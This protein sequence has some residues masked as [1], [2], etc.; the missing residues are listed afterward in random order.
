MVG[1]KHEYLNK[2]DGLYVCMDCSHQLTNDNDSDRIKYEEQEELKTLPDI[3]PPNMTVGKMSQQRGV[4]IR[5]LVEFTNK[6]NCWSMTSWEIIRKIIK[7]QTSSSRCRYVELDY[8]KEYVGEA[9][10]FISYA[11]AGLFGDL[12]AAVADHA[13]YDRYVWIDIFAVRQWPSDTPDLD[14]AS[15]IEHCSSFIIICSS[16]DLSV[17]DVFFFSIKKIPV[18]IRKMLCFLRVWCLVEIHKA[19][20]MKNMPIIMK[21][22]SHKLIDDNN[23]EF[24]GNRNMI[25]ALLY[26]VDIEK[27]EATVHSDKEMIMESIRNGCGVNQLNYVIRGVMA[28]AL[29]IVNNSS[30]VQ[31]AACGDIH[32]LEMILLDHTNIYAIAA[33]GY[34]NLLRSFIESTNC[35]IN[36]KNEEGNSAFLHASNSGHI[37]CI[38]LL[39]SYGCNIHDTNNNGESC[40][41]LA[42]SNGQAECLKY[43]ISCG[44]NV[45]HTDNSGYT[46]C[47]NA[48]MMGHVQCLKILVSHPD[49]DVYAR[50]DGWTALKWAK[51][52]QRTKAID[53]LK[54]YM[55][56]GIT[57]V[58]DD[59]DEWETDDESDGGDDGDDGGD[60]DD[61]DDNDDGDDE[62]TKQMSTKIKDNSDDSDDK[63]ETESGSCDDNDN[64]DSNNDNYN[65]NNNDDNHNNNNSIL[66]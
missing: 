57:A 46:P 31:S 62:N 47:I 36:G 51:M 16:V 41:N 29:E 50:V 39:I 7:P 60:N 58:N 3:I 42:A 53:F 4:S 43:L 5:F 17:P 55:S 10:S 22:G 48:A 21:C 64:D 6:H 40:L 65:N 56:N 61:D 18:S 19:A 38:K 13:D 37:E 59:D 14:F 20:T 44:C 35:D 54:S 15:T 52:N 2:W 32:S 30:I 1:C 34:C 12:V 63:W 23:F 49:C 45:S 9:H 66:L 11:Q 25:E 24:I 28:G 26:L 8:M 33:G 27:A